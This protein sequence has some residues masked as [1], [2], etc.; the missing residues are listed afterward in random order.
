MSD[1]IRLLDET[2]AAEYL[3]VAVATLRRWRWTGKNVPFVKLGG[4]VRYDVE[5]LNAY[6]ETCRRA[7]TSDPGPEAT[8]SALSGAVRAEAAP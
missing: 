7:S 8:P 4:C 6:I 3:R 5:D 1:S 2:E